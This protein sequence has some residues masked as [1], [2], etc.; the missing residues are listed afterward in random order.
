MTYDSDM[1]RKGHFATT[2]WSVV[3]RAGE[4][5]QPESQGALEQLCN[6][7]WY[8]LYA[9]A[10]RIGQS[11]PDAQDSAQAFF[12]RLLERKLLK[13]VKR[14]GGRFRS[15]LITSFK[16]FLADEWDKTMAQKRGGGTTSFSIDEAI[17]EKQY[18]LEPADPLS[19][20]Q[21]FERR[22]A[23][24][25]L[26]RAMAK[27]EIEYRTT[28]KSQYYEALQSSLLGGNESSCAEIAK[29]LDTT[30]GAIK[31][32]THRL[33]RAFRQQLRDTVSQTVTRPEEI[34]EEMKHLFE[35][36]I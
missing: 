8:P 17:A 26:D 16:H 13:K 11:P 6:D 33:R 31:T 14:E 7:Y 5:L 24:T 10:R 35:A 25:I 21:I 29:R 12:A 28:G 4:S 32:A 20:D 9:Y 30:E 34:E 2:H 36:L 19:P 1:Q 3:L 22:W 23:V 18:A 27:L 15:F